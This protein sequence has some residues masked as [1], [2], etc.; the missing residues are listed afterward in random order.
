MKSLIYLFL[1]GLFAMSVAPVLAETVVSGSG[2]SSPTSLTN[3]IPGINSPNIFIGMIINSVLGVVGSLALAMFIYGG[4]TWML[5]SGNKDKVQKGK[6]ILV[7]AALGMVVI[8]SAYAMVNFV[9]VDIL[10]QK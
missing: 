4:F 9:L 5:S 3:P 2:G 7:W 6:D 10:Q 1:L 8:F